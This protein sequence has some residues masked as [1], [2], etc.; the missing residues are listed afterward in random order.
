MPPPSAGPVHR[1]PVDCHR[2]HPDAYHALAKWAGCHAIEVFH[3]V[4][5]P[6][7]DLV[8]VVSKTP[9]EFDAHDPAAVASAAGRRPARADEEGATRRTS[10]YLEV[11]GRL[12]D[13]LAPRLYSR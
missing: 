13:E 1:Y 11:L 7:N 8:G 12:H 10:S 6:W 2:F 5:G 9:L 4:R 3:D